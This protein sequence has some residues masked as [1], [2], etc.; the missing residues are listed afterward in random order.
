[1]EYVIETRQLQM[2][3]HSYKVLKGIDLT[4][5]PGEII[6]LIGPS[7]VGKTTLVNV[8]TGQLIP[9]GGEAFVFGTDTEHLGDK[10][11]AAMGM[12][13]DAPG[14][15]ER[16][17]CE[18]NLSVYADIHGIDKNRISEV[19]KKVNL[20]ENAKTKAFRLSKGMRQR[21]IIARAILHS[22][23]LLFL[24]E[25]TSALDPLNTAELHKLILSLKESGTTIFLTTHRMDEAMALCDRVA[26]LC[27][28]VLI[29]N[30]APDEI[31]RKYD[32]ENSL[33]I[34]LKSG[35]KVVL[36]NIAD[37]HETI[38]EYVKNEQIVS[39]HSSEPSLEDVFLAVT[40]GG[41]RQ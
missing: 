26:L 15:F 25:P 39:I 18:Q 4:V 31:C 21:L 29:E 14:L 7:G 13:F 24:D 6:G 33:Q 1:M 2:S 41:R 12:V 20:A 16:L 19:L 10:E 30:D 23:K 28:G 22:P 5:K 40:K 32:L 17:T 27:G 37:S 8:L 34:L 35:E 9:T 36:P 3:F 11:Y 38:A